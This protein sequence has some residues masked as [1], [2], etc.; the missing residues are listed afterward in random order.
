MK[1]E[2]VPQNVIS[3]NI[4]RIRYE[5][6]LHQSQCA[7]KMGVERSNFHR[8][9]NRDVNLSILQLCQ[10]AKSLEC[11][12]YDLLKGI[13]PEVEPPKQEKLPKGTLIAF[14]GFYLDYDKK[15]NAFLTT[16]HTKDENL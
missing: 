5:K 12:I 8:L 7:E 16:K 4:K 9:E 6:R 15:G 13:E 3:D 14:T 10:I 1:K 11:S 2:L